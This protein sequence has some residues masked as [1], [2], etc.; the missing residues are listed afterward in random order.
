MGFVAQE[1][2]TVITTTN[3]GYFSDEVLDGAKVV[4]VGPSIDEW[5]RARGR[6]SPWRASLVRTR[7][8]RSG[9]VV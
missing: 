9:W 6:V 1:V 5:P 8:R 4:R 3:L 2:Q 7:R